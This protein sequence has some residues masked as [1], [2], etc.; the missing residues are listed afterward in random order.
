MVWKIQRRLPVSHVES[1]DVA[2]HVGLALAAL[3]PDL[4]AA[5]TIT[6][7]P[8]TTGVACKPDL[9]GDQ[10]DLLIVVKLQIDDAVVAEA[11]DGSAGLGVERDQAVAGRDVKNLASFFR[12]PSVQ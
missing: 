3:P 7:S 6:V 12:P 1:A 2:L 4:C 9:A 8:A 10:I 5:P 11:G